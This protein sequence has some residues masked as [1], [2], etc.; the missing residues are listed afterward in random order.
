MLQCH[1]KSTVT[2]S[3]QYIKEILSLSLPISLSSPSLS[4][5]PPQSKLLS[6]LQSYNLH[7]STTFPNAVKSQ[8]SQSWS[9]FQQFYFDCHQSLIPQ[10]LK[11]CLPLIFHFISLQNSTNI[12]CLYKAFLHPFHSQ[13]SWLQSFQKLQVYP[14]QTPK[15]LLSLGC[16]AP[17]HLNYWQ[18]KL[19]EH[20]SL[21]TASSQPP[22]CPCPVK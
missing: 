13:Q 5:S 7:L 22:T 19:R 4:F 1:M 12:I 10:A 2:F 6:Q 11:V 20:R 17:N 15:G 8:F 18:M 16:P 21:P 3:F 14:M 9:F